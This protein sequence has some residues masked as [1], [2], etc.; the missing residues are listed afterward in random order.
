MKNIASRFSIEARNALEDTLSIALSDEHD[1]GNDELKE[2]YDKITDDFPYAYDDHGDPLKLGH[3]FEE[4][5][6]VFS[7]EN[8]LISFDK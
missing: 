6:D 5:V 8:G 4:I 2:L 1:Y 3:I 7:G